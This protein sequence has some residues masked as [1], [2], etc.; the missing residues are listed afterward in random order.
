MTDATA[1]I[2]EIET[3]EMEIDLLEILHE[4]LH[5]IRAILI[6][7]FAAA[8][9][10][11]L[12][13]VFAITPQYSAS[14]M[15][16]IL[17]K[18]TSVTSLADIQMGAQLTVD[19][20]T[21]AKSRPVLEEVIEKVGLKMTYEE[22]YKMIDTENPQDT[23]ILRLAAKHP[24]AET[25]KEISNALADVTADRVAEVMDT[26]KP[27]VV[28]RAVTPK[29][30]SSPSLIKNILIGALAGLLASGGVF[31]VRFL[32]NDTIQTEEDIEKYLN[33]NTLS[34]MPMEKRGK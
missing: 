19:F 15:I 20:E 5:H 16:Y 24:N 10:A 28:E 23:R 22:L 7:L 4:L 27:N 18:T 31:V 25:A 14:S 9:A 17:T 33:L 1:E 26:D 13:T 30:P 11:A 2:K 8:T 6:C 12:I 29:K 3:N 34:A 32:L 21:L